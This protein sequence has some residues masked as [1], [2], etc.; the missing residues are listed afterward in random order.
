MTSRWKGRGSRS[1]TAYQQQQQRVVE[2]EVLLAQ[3][4]ETIADLQKKLT[5]Q[6]QTVKKLRRDRQE[7]RDKNAS[8]VGK[9]AEVS[10]KHSVAST[11][12]TPPTQPR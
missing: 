12:L 9:L 11:S 5:E 6:L 3:R 1:S 2:L 4:D 10:R 8:L 7:L